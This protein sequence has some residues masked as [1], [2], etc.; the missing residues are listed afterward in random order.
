M[1]GASINH[2]VRVLTTWTV[3]ITVARADTIPPTSGFPAVLETFNRD[4]LNPGWAILGDPQCVLPTTERAYEGAGSLKLILPGDGVHELEAVHGST[5]PYIYASYFDYG[6]LSVWLY[7]GDD[8]GAGNRAGF[9]IRGRGTD[10]YVG[11][12]SS[13]D[14]ANY[15]IDTPT[16][17]LD[18]GYARSDGW[19][20]LGIAA[21]PLGVRVKIGRV[22]TS[23]WIAYDGPTMTLKEAALRLSGP[24][25]GVAYFDEYTLF[26]F[27]IAEPSTGA[28]LLVAGLTIVAVVT[29][30]RVRRNC[31]SGL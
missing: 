25:P 2:L 17:E 10:D 24:S 30:R 9:Y 3:L 20:W 11:L 5:F 29:C 12:V 14:W 27:E 16:G 22:G 31:V 7:D 4:Q 26:R 6:F 8:I 28:L 1:K 15:R 13:P 18:T 19:Y 23:S 21:A